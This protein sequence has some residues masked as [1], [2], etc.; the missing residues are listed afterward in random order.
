ML[1]LCTPCKPVFLGGNDNLRL[2]PYHTFYPSLDQHM[3]RT[4]L[5]P[6]LNKWDSPIVTEESEKHSRMIMVVER[7]NKCKGGCRFWGKY[8]GGGSKER[9]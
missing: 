6:G 3:A 7:N 5:T 1:H 8:L 2:A 4:G 9:I